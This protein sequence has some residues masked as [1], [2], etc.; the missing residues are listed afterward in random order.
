M[1]TAPKSTS[2]AASTC[3]GSQASWVC[4]VATQLICEDRR[5]VHIKYIARWVGLDNDVRMFESAA[6]SKAVALW[7]ATLRALGLVPPD[8][9]RNRPRAAPA[10]WP[11][12]KPALVGYWRAR[13]GG[14]VE[15]CW[16]VADRSAVILP[17]AASGS[18][19]SAEPSINDGSRLP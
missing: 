19:K 2:T 18:P 4:R 9:P 7:R 13:I 1:C 12:R 15:W 17:F 16:G 10:P 6:K 5:I 14:G 11:L 3:E 8:D